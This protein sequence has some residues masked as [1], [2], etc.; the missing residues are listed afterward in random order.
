MNTLQTY[1]NTDAAYEAMRLNN[2]EYTYSL[3]KEALRLGIIDE[4]TEAEIK[5]KLLDGNAVAI[6]E[7]TEGKSS[8]VNGDKASELLSSYMYNVD[9]YLISLKSPKK[10][11]AELRE[12][13][14]KFLYDAGG[15]ALKRV[16]VDC[17]ALLFENKKNRLPDGSENY[18]RAL[19][20][21][22]RAFTKN[23]NVRFGAHRN[24]VI[25]R[26]KTALT[27][28]GSGVVRLKR[29]LTNM[30][31]ENV[32]CRNYDSAEVQTV[33]AFEVLRAEDMQSAVGNL[34][35][36]LLRCALICQYLMPGVHHVL[37]SEDDVK[38]AEVMLDEF[39]PDEIQKLLTAAFGR[40]P[41]QNKEYHKKV[42]ESELPQII[43]AIKQNN[44][45]TLLAYL[46]KTV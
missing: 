6:D 24:P 35:V 12:K 25:P 8:S 44:L 16:M 19:D 46:P 27:P 45:R 40:L 30:L 43:N 28:R 38:N 13:T 3:I 33:I 42:F 9:A 26:Y 34:Y 29:Y 41:D 21:D 2:A 7:Y 20:E 37:L 22:V 15:V 1:K 14:P 18:N 17:T 36:P 5:A 32:F 31:A 11:L 39:T 4:V 10:A 23:Y